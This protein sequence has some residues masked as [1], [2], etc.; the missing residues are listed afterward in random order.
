[1]GR[2]AIFRPCPMSPIFF[3]GNVWLVGGLEHDFYDFPYIYIH[4]HIYI[5]IHIYIHIYIYILGI[6]IHQ[7][8]G[9]L[10]FWQS[11]LLVKLITTVEEDW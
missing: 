7:P 1:M 2:A 10:P 3:A 5:Y 6:I 11:L 8:G 9:I 4:I